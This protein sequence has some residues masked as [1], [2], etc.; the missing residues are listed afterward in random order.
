MP[1]SQRRRRGQW[2]RVSTVVVAAAL[3]FALLKLQV[4]DVGAYA[5]IALEN[6]VREI[7]IPAPRGT[8][9]DRYGQVLAENVVGY[10]VLLMPAPMDSMVAQLRR[11]VPVLGL[12]D[13]DIQEAFRKWRRDGTN[14]PMTVKADAPPGAVARLEERRFLF[15]G[16][17]VIEYPKR[18]YPHGEAV[19]HFLGYVAEISREELGWPQY[20]GYRQGQLIGKAGLERHYESVVGGEPG[21]RL[22]EVDAMGRIKRWLPEETGIPPIPG[23]DLQLY[24][25]L[26]LQRY[27]MRI[28]PPGYDGAFVALDPKTGGVLAYYS[29]PGF[30]PNLFIGGIDPRLWQRLST[31]RDKPLLD[32]AGGGAQPPGSTFKLLVASMA[33]GEKVI[34]PQQYMPIPCT[35]GMS[36]QRRYARCWYGRGHGYQNLIGAIKYSCDVYFYQVGIKLGLKRFV[37]VGSRLG[38]GKPTGVDLPNE[39]PSIFPSSLDDWKRRFGY[40][41]NDNEVMSLAI[42]QGLVTLTPLKLAHMFVPLARLDGKAPAPRFVRSDTAPPITFEL[43]VTE[44]QIKVMRRGMRRVVG[45]DGTAQLSRLPGW[46]FMGKTGTAQNPHGPDHAWFVGIGGPWGGEPEI[47]AVLLLEHGEHGYTASGPVANAV[48]FYLS[49]RYGLPFNPYPTPRD[50]IPRGLPMDWRWFQSPVVDPPG[51]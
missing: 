18:H 45:P 15:P 44:Q 26:D 34:R 17:V 4:L 46:D 1:R 24:L 42:G 37:E 7:T 3:G 31:A 48:N 30:D 5:R 13:R 50:R 41:P 47:V 33:L 22:I 25:D 51:Y 12:T 21:T 39:F 35:G 2:A 6:R 9:Y 20:R 11:L 23:R 29:T 10:Q 38:F 14:L 32:R 8:I 27:I 28:F 43:P 40:R 16:V 19:A 36:Y 49:R